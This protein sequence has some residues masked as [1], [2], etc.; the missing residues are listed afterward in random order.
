MKLLSISEFIT[1]RNEPIDG[2][3]IL[4]GGAAGHMMHPFD[5]HNLTFADFKRIVDSALEGGLDFEQQP[6][7][8]ST[9]RS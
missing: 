6:T 9:A 5:D 8:K 2:K 1:E 7:E 3:L 4:E